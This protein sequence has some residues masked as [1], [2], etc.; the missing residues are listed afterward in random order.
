MTLRLVL[1]IVMALVLPAF[2]SA[3][4]AL[5]VISHGSSPM[6][7]EVPMNHPEDRSWTPATK[8]ATFVLGPGISFTDSVLQS[9][10]L[11]RSAEQALEHAKNEARDSGVNYVGPEH[12]LLGLL[13]A[14]AG[15]AA[16]VLQDARITQDK[17]RK[18]LEFI[19]GKQ[20]GIPEV[21][22]GM[23]PRTEMILNLSMQ[24]AQRRQHSV[25]STG[26]LL[27]GIVREGE[28]IGAGV[29]LAQGLNSLDQLVPSIEAR[30]HGVQEP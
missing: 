14:E 26:H 6:R 18:S 17:V 13:R 10:R 25:I 23:T 28:S 21:V 27:L 4:S 3:V 16:Q 29:L 20:P 8:N 22:H 5:G 7:A 15:L 24:E 2:I 1:L 30:L 12:L 19:T 9:M 11:T